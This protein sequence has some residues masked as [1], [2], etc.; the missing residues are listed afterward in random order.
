M[1]MHR[2]PGGKRW[3]ADTL[4]E[5]FATFPGRRR[6][7]VPFC[8]GGGESHL[9]I[10]RG[11]FRA[12]A[13]S[14]VNGELVHAHRMAA[15][16]TE[17]LLDLLRGFA[18]LP[19]DA[20]RAEF[21]RYRKVVPSG[22]N[23]RALRFFVLVGCAFNGLWRED[24]GGRFNAPWGR[25]FS[26]DEDAVRAV[27]YLLSQPGVSLRACDFEEALAAA[28]EGDLVY[29]DPPY[30]P[31]EGRAASFDS[32]AGKRFPE[33]EH[34]RLAAALL[35]AVSR[36]AVVLLSNHDSEL[37]RSIYPGDVRVLEAPRCVAADPTR[38]GIAREVLITLSG[39]R[40]HASSR[41]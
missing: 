20:Q 8:G 33:S 9:A 28:G 32:Y 3:L 37:V 30:L 11:L 26:V 15:L 4:L 23:G 29:A 5:T 6:L 7:V 40:A 2:W 18:R 24:G 16:N 36:G 13:L 38:R 25:A 31:E 35:G 39:S 14:D 1:P 17:V 10:G 27:A 12:Y 22:D 41:R 19:P 34:R 21:V